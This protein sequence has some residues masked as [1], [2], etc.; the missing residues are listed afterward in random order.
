[1]CNAAIMVYG[2]D[3]GTVKEPKY[4]VGSVRM[5][6]FT[7]SEPHLR[8]RQLLVMLRGMRDFAQREG[9]FWESYLEFRITM[10]PGSYVTLAHMI[11]DNN[12]ELSRVTN[13]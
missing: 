12:L 6:V 2:G 10:S 7:S 5:R 3:G 1:M 9:G 11:V 13:L 8:A 4:E